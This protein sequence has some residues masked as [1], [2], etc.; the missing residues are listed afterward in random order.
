[1]RISDGHLVRH[2]TQLFCIFF[3]VKIKCTVKEHPYTFISNHSFLINIHAEMTNGG[4]LDLH[5]FAIAFFELIL[6]D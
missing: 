2:T 1:M 3:S 4:Y 6:I 5:K